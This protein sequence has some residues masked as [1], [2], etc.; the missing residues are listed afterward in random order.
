MDKIKIKQMRKKQLFVTN[1]LL[2][3]LLSI[4]FTVISNFPV[5]MAEMF[6]VLGA[7]LFFQATVGFFKRNPT[8]SIIPIFEKVAIYEKE[9]M[10]DEWRKQRKTSVIV[11]F[12]LGGFMLFQFYW[13]H[14]STDPMFEKD[15][16]PAL[17]VIFLVVIAMVN[18]QLLLHI[19]KV[20]HA[21]S[22]EDLAGYTKNVNVIGIAT[23]VTIAFVMVVFI[24][25]YVMMTS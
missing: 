21:K 3:C 19:K 18:I 15:I 22:A 7:W 6:F 17:I 20:D 9:K 24:I 10:G 23:G 13:T 16:M 1:V 5:T 11:Q 25:S 12:L 2:L 8:R 4:Y 14:G